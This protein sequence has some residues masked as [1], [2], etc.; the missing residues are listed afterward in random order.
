M[1]MCC[2][3]LLV[4]TLLLLSL[5]SLRTAA[6]NATSQVTGVVSDSSGAMVTGAEVQIKNTDTNAVRTTTTNDRGEYS[7][8]NLPIGPYSLQ[9]SKTGY[10]TYVQSG[11][12]LQVNTNPSINVA[13]AVGSVT[14]QVEVSVNSAM[15]ETQN[16]TVSQVINPHQ[17]VDLPLNGRQAEQLIALSGAAVSATFTNTSSSVA[18]TALLQTLD[19][20]T[21]VA[22]SIAG[23]QPN[24]TN[25]YL[26][27]A[28]H[29]DFRDN[30]GLPMPFPDALSEFSVNIS[31][32]PANLGVHPGGVIN[33]VTRG[34]GNGF[35]GNIF[36][37][38]R[39]GVMDATT[40]TFATAEGGR[41][42][43]GTRDTLVRNQFGG[44][45]GGPIR[46]DKIFFFGG[47]QG[48]MSNS[49]TGAAKVAVPTLAMIGMGST[50]GS[51]S[52]GTYSQYPGYGDLSA[53]L[54]GN[55]YGCTAAAVS[56][57][58]T[59]T[60]GAGSNVIDSAWINTP[61]A[62]VIQNMY[63]YIPTSGFYDN[64]G[65]Y[66]YKTSPNYNF[67]NQIVGRV[68]WQRNDK[69]RIFGRYFISNYVQPVY[70]SNVLFAPN[71][72]GLSD[73]I[74][75][76]AIGDDYMLSDHTI[77]TVRLSFDRTATQRVSNSGVPTWCSL[78][79]NAT[80]QVKN[81]IIFSFSGSSLSTIAPGSV[82]EPGNLG[83]DYENSY[84]VTDG[85]SWAKGKNQIYAGF[86]WL[87]VQMNG[88]GLFQENP[89]ATYNGNYTGA[90]YGDWATGNADS[91]VQGMGQLSRDGENQ[92]SAYFQESYKLLPR[93]QLTGGLR[94]D[95]FIAQHNKY[96]EVGDFSLAGYLNNV[97]SQVY[98]NAPPGI[99]FEGDPGFHGKSDT[100][101]YKMSFA[102]R[103]GFVWDV[104]GKGTETLRG[105]YGM[106]YDTS[107]LWNTMHVVLNPPWG[108]TLTFTPLPECITAGCTE[109][110]IAN[111]WAGSNGPNP[112][113]FFNPPKSF[114]FP[115]SG[116]Y[117]FENQANKPQTV[118][119]WN[120][121]FQRQMTPNTLVTVNYIGNKTS[122]VWLGINLN[123]DTYLSQYGT[124]GSC[125]I[126]YNV[127]GTIQTLNYTVC[128]EPTGITE[129]DS[130]GYKVTNVNARRALSLENPTWGSKM[131]GG[132]L[133]SFAYGDGAYNGVLFSVEK[134]M[135]HGFQA[136][137][138]YTWSRCMDDGEIGQDVTNTPM[139][140]A[141][142]KGSMWGNCSYSNKG[143]MN[144]SVVG[145]SPHFKNKA[146]SM[147]ASN[148]AGSGV[149]T[150][151]TGY[152]YTMSANFDSSLTGVGS[153]RPVR[154]AN[155]KAGGAVSASPS[156]SAPSAVRNIAHWYNPCAFTW[157][158]LGT[159]SS[160]RRNDQI[161]P[162]NWNLN[163]AI[164][165]SFPVTEKVHLDLRA[166]AFNAL[167]HTQLGNPNLNLSSST[168]AESYNTNAG[169]ISTSGPAYQPRIFQLAIKASF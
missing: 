105:G 53:T 101:D 1:R 32:M 59:T 141:D 5:S 140:P 144:L 87:H 15:V 41:A 89:N 164:W 24:A 19:Y 50:T 139:N 39:N 36:D 13:L 153:D 156:C 47:Y 148:W 12:V 74:Q 62:K 90:A 85:Y 112:F 138:N 2:R 127:K 96:G 49:I 146:V 92:P 81:A 17:V 111:I 11:I 52:N 124:T 14:Q 115:N 58:Y 23:S 7:F 66:S 120:L 45:I 125:T 97:S 46:K 43:P 106:F 154:I 110:G 157:A 161:G 67:E 76:V 28:E 130:T 56:S 29:L 60:N 160:E 83:Y 71:G 65:D 134:R 27:G 168:K 151:V 102:P 30:I 61:S 121:S 155:P 131:Q 167:N 10:K 162:A 33:G 98:V 63:K 51:T 77:N 126:P 64:C 3:I 48:T 163:L 143:I 104:T 9:V 75:T 57:T 99:T 34:G 8:P 109:G 135:S 86:T 4:E 6:Q 79:A 42:T 149:Y 123:P 88:D 166:E 137:G 40:R 94:W 107:V 132:V 26:D 169:L 158:P 113:P 16:A 20:P 84:G 114:T 117:V 82:T 122:H 55:P 129:N 108:E 54:A 25:Y 119:A 73:R 18:Q 31:A 72:A 22:Y 128:N 68:D 91:I 136:L 116:S 80:C 150:F 37:F 70:F 21:S 165:R 69:D 78:G 118:Q 159:F 142:P 145:Q 147:V 152:P 44:T 103:I 35:H 93:L 100:N 38:V 95:P 133:Q